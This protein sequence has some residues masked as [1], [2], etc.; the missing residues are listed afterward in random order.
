MRMRLIAVS[1]AAL[2]LGGQA[3]AVPKRVFDALTGCW[4][5]HGAVRGQAA[6]QLAKG[7]WTLGGKYFLL[8]LAA[9]PPDKPYQAAIFVGTDDHGQVVA[10]WLDV[11]GGE[12]SKTLGRGS[13]TADGLDLTFDYPDG[14]TRNRVSLLPGGRWRML[15]T[16]TPKG[17]AER[18]FSDYELTP[19]ACPAAGVFA[20]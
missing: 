6:H 20:F 18:V 7:G 4:Q 10:H 17:Q 1:A 3:H 16:E 9:L 12:Y 2:L 8:Q 19:A 14:P 5:V 13:E 11:F 15:V